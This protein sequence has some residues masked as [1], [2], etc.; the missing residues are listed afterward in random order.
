M[1]VAEIIL[2]AQ[3]LYGMYTLFSQTKSNPGHTETPQIIPQ[4]LHRIPVMCVFY[5]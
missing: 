2:T 1:V 3:E 4:V 5:C